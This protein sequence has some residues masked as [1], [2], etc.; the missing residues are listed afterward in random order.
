MADAD[1]IAQVISNYLSNALKYST[2]DQTIEVIL[3][4]EGEGVRLLVRDRGPGLSQ[5]EQ[6]RVWE[7]FYRV[8]G[9]QV[10]NGSGIGPGLGLAICSF[11]VEAHG[12]QVGVESVLGEGIVFWFTLPHGK[13]ISPMPGAKRDAQSTDGE[14]K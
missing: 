13:S 1:R 11:L 5:P 12:G 9:I 3:Q 7:R 10:Q 14:Q 4:E 8:P 2:D 6:E